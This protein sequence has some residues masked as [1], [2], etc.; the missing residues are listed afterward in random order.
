LRRIPDVCLCDGEFCPHRN[1]HCQE[2]PLLQEFSRLMVDVLPQSALVA[3]MKIVS[4]LMV[5][6]PNRPP[7]FCGYV[8]DRQQRQQHQHQVVA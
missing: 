1:E 5:A 4:T 3:G 8:W 2:C 7:G 6:D